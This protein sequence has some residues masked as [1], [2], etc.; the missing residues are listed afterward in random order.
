MPPST[1][2]DA[3]TRILAKLRELM[4][5]APDTDPVPVIR[6]A[7]RP[8]DAAADPEQQDAALS[9]IERSTL[10]LVMR[11]HM[12]ERLAASKEPGQ[13]IEAAGV[14]KLLDI[15]IAL[16]AGEGCDPNTPFALLEDLFDAHVISVAE[17]AFALVEARAAALAPFLGSEAKFQRCK[18]TLIRS[19]NELLRRLSKSKNTN[20]RGRVLMFM[21]Y[22]FP[23]AERSGVNLKGVTSPSTVATE[24]EGAAGEEPTMV[25]TP[26]AGA[27]SGAAGSAAGGAAGGEGGG[28]VNFG[29][30]ATFWGLQQAFAKP[31]SSV[32]KEAWP[33]LV[34]HLQTVLQVFG[35]FSGD[36][37]GAEGTEGSPGDESA[38]DAGAGE[39]GEGEALDE[40]YFAKFLTSSKLI[41]LQLR[42]G[43]FRRHVL[44]QILIFLQT[45]TTERRGQPVLSAAQRQQVDTLHG[46]CIELLRAIP[47]GGPKFA[48]AVLLMLEREEHWIRWKANGCQAFDKAATTAREEGLATRKRKS[49]GGGVK[50]VSL[51]NSALTRLWNMGGNSLEDIAKRQQEVMPALQE[52]LQPVYEQADPEAGIEEEYKMKNDKAFCWKAF[53]LIA[54]NDVGLL[55]K[56]SAPGGSLEAAAKHLFDNK[57]GSATKEE[58][59]TEAQPEKMEE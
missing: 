2:D 11:M 51:G 47:P 8:A 20:F 55:S 15:A 16:A 58:P 6:E 1:F 22:T 19:C 5:A 13:T 30:Y 46:R 12:E 52:Y 41:T 10:E 53:R 40:V 27:A 44:V 49:V 36:A 25:D 28:V 31:A 50:K 37:G 42:D 38:A 35:S 9:E 54:K 33:S 45:V 26:G 14:P 43:Y 39:S 57:D 29:F 24:E 7:L 56:V 3:K 18:L 21:A 4:A 59:L 17:S 23:L 34:E 48:Q 32:S